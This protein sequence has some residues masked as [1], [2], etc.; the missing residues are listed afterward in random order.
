M[1]TDFKALTIPEGEV[2]KI[3]DSLGRVLWTK[4]S[5]LP[6]DAEIEYLEG[7]KPQYIETG[8][9][10]TASTGLRIGIFNK[11]TSDAYIAGLRDVASSGRFC[12]GKSN[13]Y[14]YGYGGYNYVSVADAQVVCDLDFNDDGFFRVRNFNSFAEI[15]SLQLPS[16]SFTP[17][18][19]IRLFGSAGVSA[20]YTQWAGQ[21]FFAQI[22]EGSNL[23]MD[24]IPVRVGQVGY[25]YDKVSGQLFGNAGTG[26]F[27]L[28]PDK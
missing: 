16:L 9:I 8:I 14:Y 2:V 25:M 6:Y 7:T 11:N 27:G 17:Q 15:A 12:I 26:D 22:T 23:I 5:A 13:T 20:S 10:P 18:D 3:E 1:I 19:N 28:G 21:L 24:L 4:P